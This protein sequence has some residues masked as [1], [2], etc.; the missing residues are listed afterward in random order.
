MRTNASG[1][2]AHIRIPSLLLTLVTHYV[3]AF[4]ETK[5]KCVEK[6]C[7]RPGN[8]YEQKEQGRSDTG[9]Y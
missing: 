6:A 7:D 3:E 5:R 8:R 4:E 1:R 9:K 2:Q